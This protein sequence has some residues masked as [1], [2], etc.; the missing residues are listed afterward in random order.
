MLHVQYCHNWSTDKIEY[1]IFLIYKEI[2]KGS[3][4]SHIWLTTSSYIINHICVFPHKLG[5]PSSYMT[6]QL[7][8]SEFPLYM[9]KI[10]FS[11]FY[12]WVM[13]IKPQHN[14]HLS[15]AN[16]PQV[17]L[18]PVVHL[19]LQISPRI[20]KKI[21]NGHNGILWGWGE[22]DSW[23]NQKHKISSH[24]PFKQCLISKWKTNMVE[25]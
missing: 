9:R 14:P 22:T 13:W 24:C 4:Q 2:Q 15:R 25:V 17:S 7:L 3:L 16:L 5:S 21:R 19:D 23:K 11:F 10:S 18:I 12:Q 20:F 8:P 6:L 1:Q